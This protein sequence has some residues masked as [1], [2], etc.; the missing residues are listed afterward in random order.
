MFQSAERRLTRWYLLVLGIVLALYGG[1]VFVVVRA[2]LLDAVDRGNA[3]ALEPIARRFA[4]GGD[5]LEDVVHELSEVAVGPGDFVAL[6]APDGKILTAR[7]AEPIAAGIR[8]GRWTLHRKGVRILSLALERNGQVRGYLA[9]GRSLSEARESI[10]HIAICFAAMVPLALFAAWYGG[11]W[12]AREAMRPVEAALTRER[13]LTRDASHELRTPIAA[14]LAQAQVALEDPGLSGHARA[15]IEAIAGV[16]R[17]LAGL[18]ADLLTLGRLDAGQGGEILAFD[19]QEVVEEELEALEP[20]ASARNLS[21]DVQMPDMPC[22]VSGEPG[23]IGQAIRNLLDNAI[24]YSP[25]G[26][27]VR[28]RLAP[29]GDRW[30]LKVSN[31]ATIGASDRDRVFE[32]FGRLDEGRRLNPEGTGLGLALARAVARAHGGDLTLDP[33]GDRDATFRLSLPRA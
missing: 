32:R 31:P 6:A 21:L 9:I 29:D 30:V 1:A 14:I 11:R 24:R 10:G 33:G 20:L 25:E 19:L 4:E 13:E 12:L 15:R 22:R 16:A 7:G 27:T 26:A 3:R 2:E 17:K 18:V 23:R 5:D 28:L 8:T